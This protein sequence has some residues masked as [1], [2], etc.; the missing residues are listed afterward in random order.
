MI[1]SFRK[2]EVILVNLNPVIGSEMAKVRPCLI[3]SPNAVNSALNTLIVV[4]FTTTI[5]KYPT[6]IITNHKGQHGSLAFDQIKSIDKSRVIKKDSELDRNL[7]EAATTLL[8]VMF[9]EE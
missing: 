3:V 8:Q 5:K 1:K 2:W 7:R 9:S 4:P 6:R